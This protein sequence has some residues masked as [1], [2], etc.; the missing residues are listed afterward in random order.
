MPIVSSQR[1][2]SGIIGRGF[3]TPYL[4][5]QILTTGYVAGGYKDSVPWRNV[6]KLNMSTDTGASLGDLLQQQA[7]Y[8]SGAHNRDIAFIWNLSPTAFAA[9]NVTGCFNMRTDTTYAKT[10]SMDSAVTWGD[11]ATVQEDLTRAWIA[12]SGSSAIVQRFDLNTETSTSTFALSVLQ[13]DGIGAGAHYD[14][15]QGRFWGDAPTNMKL[16]YATET[17]SS[18]GSPGHHSQ[19]K[20]ITSKVGFGWAGNEG[21]Y[22]AGFQLRKWNYTTESQVALVAKPIGDSGEENFCMGQDHNWMLGM[23]NTAG[24][25]NRAWKFTFATDSGFEGGAGMQ[26]SAPGI[27]G[28][29]S[30]HCFWRD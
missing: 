26:P 20:G 14:D 2:T 25:N 4:Y 30:G 6:W 1:G 29:S 15:T 19:Q 3:R 17:Q 7:M 16:T 13:N 21:T 10:S 24:Q 12:G 9:S 8:T 11:P 18:G 27:A 28:R 5:R 22:N 23:Y